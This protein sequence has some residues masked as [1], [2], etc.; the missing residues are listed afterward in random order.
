MM[1]HDGWMS[2]SMGGWLPIFVLIA[3]LVIAAAIMLSR[4]ARR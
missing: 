3:A 1:N 4:R 2:G